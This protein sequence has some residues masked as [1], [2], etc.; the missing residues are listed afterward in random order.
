MDTGRRRELGAGMKRHKLPLRESANGMKNMEFPSSDIG[1]HSPQ[2]YPQLNG[3]Q[4]RPGE[5]ESLG[6]PMNIQETAKLL[7]CSV[8]TVRQRYLA[9]GLPHIRASAV[10][11]L[12]FFRKQV[13]DWVFKRQRKQF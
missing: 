3:S 10:G 13:I 1:Q 2:A 11:R 6:D 12:V 5:Q 4:P 7:G 8:W 9:Q